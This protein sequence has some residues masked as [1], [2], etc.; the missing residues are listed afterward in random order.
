MWECAVTMCKELVNQYESEAF[1]C[2]DIRDLLQQ[3]STFYD[4]ILKQSRSVPV[5]FKI[6]YY[7]KGFPSYL[8]NKV[9]IYRDNKYANIHIFSKWIKDQFPDATLMNTLSQPESQITESSCQCI[10][11][12]SIILN[13]YIQED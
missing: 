11:L 5:Y 9:F 10:L 1:N 8:Q 3:M 12:K 6:A 7:G 13:N 2:M 4:K